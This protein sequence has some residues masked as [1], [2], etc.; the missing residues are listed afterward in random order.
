MRITVIVKPHSHEARV[1]EN[2]DGTYFVRV[3]VPP[4]S[5]KANEAIRRLLA[6]E[7]E[8]PLSAVQI[9]SGPRARKKIV[10]INR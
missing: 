4:E 9:I 1:E 3:T 7:F 8:V 5:G 2:D 10:A 6:A